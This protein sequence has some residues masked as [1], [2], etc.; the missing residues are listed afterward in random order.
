MV[1]A[2]IYTKCERYDEAL[3]QID[4]LLSQESEYTVNA[5]KLDKTFDP[6]REMA[7]FQALM[8]KYALEPNL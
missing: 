7:E 8:E 3:E 6:L 5:F 1:M 2:Q 4:Y